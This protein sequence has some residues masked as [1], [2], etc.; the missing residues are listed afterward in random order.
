MASLSKIIDVH[1]HIITNLGSQAPMDKLPPWSIEQSLSLMD[2]NGIAAS[3]LSLPDSADHANGPEACQL[4]RRINEQLADIV[5]KHPTRFGAMATLPALAGTDGL[6]KEMTYAL[7]ALKLDGVATSTSID[8]IYL[9]DTRYDP[10]FEEMNRR[11]VTLF[12]HPVPAKASRSVDLGIDPSLLEF[13]FDTHRPVAFGVHV[14]HYTHAH[15]Y[16]LQRGQEPLLKD[17]NHFH[18]WRG[19]DAI[20]DDA[21]RNS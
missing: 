4:A 21:Y 17:Q 12:V 9:G 15:Q 10:W 7:D 5:S 20:C 1:S 11:G 16:D 3:V 14:R 18:P 6:L 8:D 13:M 19:N 2:A